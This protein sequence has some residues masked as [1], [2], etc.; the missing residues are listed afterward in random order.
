MAFAQPYVRLVFL[1]WFRDKEKH[2]FLRGMVA[3]SLAIF[4]M[5]KFKYTLDGRGGC[6]GG[7]RPTCRVV[8][9]VPLFGYLFEPSPSS[10]RLG[11]SPEDLE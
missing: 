3:H 2:P 9:N 8:G 10:D 5:L 4:E 11:T 7:F 1:F 6:V